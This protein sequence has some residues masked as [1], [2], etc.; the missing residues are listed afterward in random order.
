MADISDNAT[1][2]FTI[3]P[4]LSKRNRVWMRF[5]TGMASR[6]RYF[7]HCVDDRAV[8]SSSINDLNRIIAGT[9]SRVFFF[10]RVCRLYNGQY[11]ASS[12]RSAFLRTR[13]LELSGAQPNSVSGSSVLEFPSIVKFACSFVCFLFVFYIIYYV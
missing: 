13:A 11:R 1:D 5:T 8:Q 9:I 10:Y 7:W 4:N 3:F 2:R 12:T 6:Q